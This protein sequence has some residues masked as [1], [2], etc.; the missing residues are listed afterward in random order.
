MISKTAI[1]SGGIRVFQIL[2]GLEQLLG[3]V[4]D[5]GSWSFAIKERILQVQ[6]YKDVWK[7]AVK[8]ICEMVRTVL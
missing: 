3:D 1:I 2:I 7:T 5:F 6:Q 8:T 4:D